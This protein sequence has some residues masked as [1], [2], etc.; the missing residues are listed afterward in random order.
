LS[1][2]NINESHTPRD[3]K[4]ENVTVSPSSALLYSHAT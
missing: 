3:R 2:E 1:M 4:G